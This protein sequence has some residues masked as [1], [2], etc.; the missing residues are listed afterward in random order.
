[1]DQATAV[2]ALWFFACF[3]F[4]RLI[5][6]MR[7][8]TE[9]LTRIHEVNTREVDAHIYDWYPIRYEILNRGV[10]IKN[11]FSIWKWSVSSLWGKH[12]FLFG[13]WLEAQVPKGTVVP[14][15]S[16]PQ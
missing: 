1:M 8:Y 4:I 10:H 5:Y 12:H 3:F 7:I 14:F 16:T 6:L 2:L 15:H 9:L 13:S 11:L